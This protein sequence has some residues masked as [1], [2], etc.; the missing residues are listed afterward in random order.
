ML[1]VYVLEIKLCRKEKKNSS[2]STK[3]S[4][5]CKEN[6]KSENLVANFRQGKISIHVFKINYKRKS[7]NLL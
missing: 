4:F 1:K 7:C 3:K 5:H 2:K 6:R